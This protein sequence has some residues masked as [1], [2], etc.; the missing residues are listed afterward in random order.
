M[1]NIIYSFIPWFLF[2]LLMQKTHLPLCVI[3]LITLIISILTNYADLKKKFILPCIS[4]LFFGI[5]FI[6]TAIFKLDQFVSYTGIVINAILA[7]TVFST[8]LLKQP[9]TLQYAKEQLPP[10]RWQDPT[11]IFINNFLTS[12]WGGIFLFNL[13]ISVFKKCTIISSLTSELLT[14]CSIIIGV[15][16]VIWF[17]RLYRSYKKKL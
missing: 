15:L 11:F 3:M 8:L 4:V 6:A 2:S 12:V 1:L 7:I 5:G 13:M 16:A 9:F 14:N 17:P 10:K